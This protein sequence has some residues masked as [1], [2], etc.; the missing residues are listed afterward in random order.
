MGCL[1]RVVPYR[2][3]IFCATSE[4]PSE[5]KINSYYKNFVGYSHICITE[6]MYLCIGVSMYLCLCVYVCVDVCVN[7]FSYIILVGGWPTPLKNMSSSVGINYYSQYILENKSHVWNHQPDNIVYVH[8]FPE[9]HN[10]FLDF[11]GNDPRVGRC[12]HCFFAQ[13]VGVSPGVSSAWDTWSLYI[14]S[15]F[16][17]KCW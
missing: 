12:S 17:W 8:I 11:H 7:T 13:G 14:G 6:Y 1:C 16:P 2:L 5:A 4:R 9:W 3:W 10:K 15:F